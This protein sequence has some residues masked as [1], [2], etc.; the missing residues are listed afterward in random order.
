MRTETNSYCIYL[1]LLVPRPPLDT[2]NK[3]DHETEM[4]TYRLDDCVSP[5][6]PGNNLS[7]Y[8]IVPVDVVGRLTETEG[9]GEKRYNVSLIRK[10]YV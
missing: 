3:T 8:G 2:F 7:T 6:V 5:M 10:I 4:L 1:K 9:Q